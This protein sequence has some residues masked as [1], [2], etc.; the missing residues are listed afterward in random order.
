MI[1]TPK[2]VFTFDII[3]NVDSVPIFTYLIVQRNVTRGI[4]AE[5]ESLA[6]YIT[7]IDHCL[8]VDFVSRFSCLYIQQVKELGILMLT[9][10]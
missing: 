5:H 7:S 6:S 10:A 2:L 1:L 8:C 9:S 4:V 3:F